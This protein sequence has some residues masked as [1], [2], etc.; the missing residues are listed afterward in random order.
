MLRAGN[1]RS[2]IRRCPL[3]NC[4]YH[5][6]RLDNL[7]K[8]LRSNRHKINNEDVV[9]RILEMV[10][11]NSLPEETL[12]RVQN[13]NIVQV[14]VGSQ[15][16]RTA[17]TIPTAMQSAQE[18]NA[19][20]SEVLQSS[21]AT[22]NSRNP[23]A[24]DG[25]LMCDQRQSSE[26]LPPRQLS[27]RVRAPPGDD[28]SLAE[29]VASLHA[30]IQKIKIN[31]R[32]MKTLL[33]QTKSVLESKISEIDQRLEK[34]DTITTNVDSTTRSLVQ[35]QTTYSWLQVK[36]QVPPSV[37][38]GACSLC[39]RHSLQIRQHRGYS[40]MQNWLNCSV[41]LD[42]DHRAQKVKLHEQSECHK[43]CKSEEQQRKKNAILFTSQ[44]KF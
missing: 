40:S 34:T 26:Q 4:S 44:I 32:D 30:A 22:Q 13:D 12:L 35:L 43:I 23:T 16:E 7:K 20:G 1:Y 36:L 11:S 19:G 28:N 5:N 14:T 33:E 25:E 18:Q 27:Q 2:N 15:L 29:A 6:F 31:E 10:R 41:V 37:P 9:N 21:T 42:S 3:M 38:L 17:S 39:Q 8:H 24:D